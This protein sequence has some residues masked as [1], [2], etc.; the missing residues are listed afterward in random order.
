MSDD[1]D[2]TVELLARIRN[3]DDA[4]RETLFTRIHARVLAMVQRRM[5]EKLRARYETEDL[6]Q[7]V[8]ADAV[9]NLDKFEYRDEGALAKWLAT[10][11]EN[12]LRHRARGLEYGDRAP[13]RVEPIGP[14]DENGRGH[15]PAGDDTT[16]SMFVHRDE[17]REK[18][19]AA[20]A[21]L[22]ERERTLIE[23]RDLRELDWDD[24]VREA[25]E[26]TKKAA[27]Q[28][29]ARAWARLA[30]RLASELG[31]DA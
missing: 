2:P 21:E 16:P 1:P 8:L 22:T 6:A 19:G 13:E 4:A 31:D 12:K 9:K 11:V 29:H 25:G 28:C 23:L 18:L 27:Q 10:Y 20:M 7:S 15:D 17:R 5:G 14:R 3:G 26:P 30:A 24:V